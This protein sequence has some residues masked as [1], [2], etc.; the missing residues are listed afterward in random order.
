MCSSLP[1]IRGGVLLQELME[2]F[3]SLSHLM[4][5]NVR[6]QGGPIAAIEHR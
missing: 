2:K 3:P 5:T 4:A 6:I 1:V